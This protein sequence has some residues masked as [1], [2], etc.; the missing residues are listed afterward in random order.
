[1]SKYLTKTLTFF[2][3]LTMLTQSLNANVRLPSLISDNLVLQRDMPLKIWG[4]AD[5]GE[6]V[7]ISFRGKNYSTITGTDGKW[8]VK[9]SKQKTGAPSD[10]LIKGKN[11]ILIKNILVGDVWL[12]GGQ[13]NMGVQLGALSEKYKDELAKSSNPDIRIT[14]LKS[15]RSFTLS[16][17]ISASGWEEAG[18]VSLQKFSAVAY[19]FGRDIYEYTKVPVGLISCNWG[20]TMAEAWTSAE[21]LKDFPYLLDELNRIKSD[22]L[23]EEKEKEWLTKEKYEISKS[24]TDT[25]IASKLGNTDGWK[26]MTLPSSWNTEDL[27]QF[28]GV[29]WYTRDFDL[30]QSFGGKEIL[31]RM[32]PVDDMDFTYLNGQ[33]VGFTDGYYIPRKYF[34]PKGLA[35]P[36]KNTITIRMT[37]YSGLGGMMGIND[38][39]YMEADG[40][41]I[42]LS[43]IWKYKCAYKI[44]LPAKPISKDS[45]DVPTLLFN[46]MIHPLTGFSIKG[47][48]WYQGESNASRADGYYK[49]FPALIADWR[50]AWGYDF[51]FLYVQLPN[52]KTADPWP[53]LREA[54]ALTLKTPETGMAV[55]I[56]IGDPSD[57]HPRNKLDV[58]KRLAI[59][60]RK[61]AYGENLVYSGPTFKSSKIEGDK[62]RISFDNIGSGLFIKGNELEEFVI[63]DSDMKFVSATAQIEDNTI[64]V[65]CKAVNK[66]VAVRYAWSS[67]PVNANLYNK[68]GL[69]AGPFRTDK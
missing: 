61:V 36:G 25:I 6:K 55:T 30:P 28:D 60:A 1:M 41:R 46:G 53:E 66:P 24:L 50:H 49:L 57:I 43:G 10:M 17:D 16:D 32:P 12:C 9:L 34:I 51:P 48:I 21:G 69:P 33:K 44:N 45:P 26:T 18:P 38:D 20:G 14:T 3:I 58:G 52:F 13:S 63:A 11:K 54:Q 64:V 59:V 23:T 27:A 5:V 65:S 31:I 67:C 7:T 40:Q 22:T 37:D 29:V 47:V 42:L 39:F 56:D 68:E 4:W 8:L 35:R 15:N 2:C 19:F 62:I